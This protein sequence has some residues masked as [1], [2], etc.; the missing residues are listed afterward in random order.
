MAIITISRKIAS[1]GD[2]TAIELAKLLNYNF[3]DRKSLE[4]DLLARGISEAQLKKYDERKPSFWASLSR[5]RDS[6]FICVKQYMSTRLQATAFL[7]AEEVS[8]S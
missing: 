4:K 1:F 2:E 5:E 7:S 3:V 6:Y 8:Q